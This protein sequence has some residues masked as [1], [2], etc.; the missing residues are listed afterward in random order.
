MTPP[1]L[2]VF[3]Q[4]F[5]PSSTGEVD[6]R[7]LGEVRQ[8]FQL[9]DRE[10][11]NDFTIECETSCSGGTDAYTYWSNIHVCPLFISES[12]DVRV[13]TIIH[14]TTHGALQAV[15]RPYEWQPEY[16][17][18]TPRG[19]TGTGI[20]VIGPLIRLIARSDTLYAPDAYSYFAAN[21]P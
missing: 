12:E 10:L 5:D 13:T 6:Q 7:F 3:N 19:P 20:P 11:H 2:A 17:H 18:L 4:Y 1:E 16:A 21:V 15:D 9:I 14:E 8:N